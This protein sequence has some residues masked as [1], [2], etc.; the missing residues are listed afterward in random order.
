MEDDETLAAAITAVLRQEGYKVTAVGDGREGLRLAHAERPDIVLLDVMLPSMNGFEVCQRLRQDPST[1]LLPIAMLSALGQIKDRITGF[2]LGA[3][4]Y[5]AKPFETAELLARLERT[6]KRRR[7]ELAANPLTGLPGGVAFEQDVQ[8][9][10]ASGEPFTVGRADV[11]GLADFNKAYGYERGDHVIRLV[12]LILRSAAQEL[13][14]KTDVLCH[15]GGDDFGFVST[16]PRAE[17]LA[18]R[19]LE[20]AEVLLLMPYDEEDRMRGEVRREHPAQRSALMCLAIGLVDVA[21]G[22]GG[23]HMP[24]LDDAAAA[25]KEAKAAGR[26][27]LVRRALVAG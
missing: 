5:I 23:H 13:G 11:S 18:A 14:N 12:G 3:D 21:A 7:E 10:L 8:R 22:R 26:H 1:C 25:L 20:N 2:K 17:V 24:I 6:L 4:E 27:H 19:A 9:R 15:L 16:P